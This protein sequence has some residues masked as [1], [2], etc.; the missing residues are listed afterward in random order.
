M[1]GHCRSSLC[2]WDG[3]QYREDDGN[4]AHPDSTTDDNLEADSPGST[5]VH[6][7]CCQKSSTNDDENPADV[8][9]QYQILARFLD[10][11][12]RDG[13]DQAEAVRQRKVEVEIGQPSEL[14]RYGHSS[15][16]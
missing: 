11:N 6:A 16:I 9:Y 15:H 8:Q 12:A 13:R 10:R 14:M 5:A 3:C 1:K 4:A 2:D 7:Q